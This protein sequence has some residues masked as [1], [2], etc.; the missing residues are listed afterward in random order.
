MN[1][2]QH[3]QQAHSHNIS[4]A[5][6]SSNQA[7]RIICDESRKKSINKLNLKFLHTS[8]H[9]LV[10]HWNSKS[11]TISSFLGMPL[12]ERSSCFSSR[13]WKWRENLK[14]QFTS[15]KIQKSKF[16]SNLPFKSFD[17]SAFAGPTG[18][19]LIFSIT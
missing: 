4:F 13:N 1:S 11:L 2:Y 9:I 3:S 14:M 6:K 17:P 7:A 18:F 8:L 5:K 16:S 15:E 19:P 12:H 10:T